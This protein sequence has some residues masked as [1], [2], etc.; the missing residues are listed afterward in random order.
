MHHG[1]KGQP[2]KTITTQVQI[3]DT[4]GQE[5]F[6]QITMEYL[7]GSLGVAFAYDVTDPSSL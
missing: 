5:K 2:I 4:A 3:W 1:N 7:G 6:E